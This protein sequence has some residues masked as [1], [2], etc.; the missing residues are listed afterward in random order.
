MDKIKSIQVIPLIRKL[1]QVFEGSTYRIV[2]RNTLYVRV[3]TQEGIIGEAFGGDE[4]IHQ[5]KVVE[6]ANEFLAPPLI[7]QEL[8]PIEKLWEMMF[9]TQGLPFHNRSIHTLDMVNH[10]I[11]MQ[12]IAAIDMGLWD[13]LGKQLR[14]PLATLWGAHR[15]R[16][17]VLGIGGYYRPGGER[18]LTEEINRYIEL[19]LSGI[20]LKVGRWSVDEDIKRVQLIR[21]NF[22]ESFVI[23][24][25]A[26]QAWSYPQACQFAGGVED[27]RVE[28][29]EEPLCWYDQIEGMKR[30]R[31]RTSIP[32]VA[33]QGEISSWGCRDL[34]L[35]GCVD[36]L[37]VD[38]TI[39][40]GI[41]EWRKIASFANLMNINMGHHEEPQVAL[42]LLAAI[43]NGKFVEIFPDRERDPMWYEL[44]AEQPKISQ[45]Y[46][47]LPETPGFGLT[48]NEDILNRYGERVKVH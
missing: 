32:I 21:K 20:K 42:H 48:Y 6:I 33:G 34:I 26:N 43:P 38:A 30:L 25:D 46:M 13:T 18:Q 27:L 35:N 28:W 23:A 4:D 19:G 39:A 1:K 3:E 22:P 31:Q 41:T 9:A 17:P 15:D 5:G 10:A 44:V 7:G 24:C 11:L 8:Q 29:L 2:S 45:G 16:V 14:K 47:Y 40:G 12:A 36:M 37:N